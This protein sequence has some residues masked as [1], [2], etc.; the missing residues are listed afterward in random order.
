MIDFLTSRFN[1]L[2]PTLQ[3]VLL[4]DKKRNLMESIKIAFSKYPSLGQLFRF[5]IIGIAAA[6]T[7][8][9]GVFILVH[10][11]HLHPLLANV[12]AFLVAFQVSFHGHKF[13]T[14]A[15]EAK[16]LHAMSKFLVVALLSFCL[17]EGLYTYFLLRLHLNYLVA[18]VIVL[19]IVPPITFILSKFW[20]FA[21]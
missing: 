6:C 12:F 10:F 7:Q 17:N 8:F 13:W 1:P 9:A 5:G 3:T 2:L 11:F 18:L 20:A 16:H 21:T 15:S 4:L 19:I 14:F